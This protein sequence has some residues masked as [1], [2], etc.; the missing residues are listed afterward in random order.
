M[1]SIKEIDRIRKSKTVI[2]IH[3]EI[4]VH[5]FFSNPEI[6]YRPRFML[7]CLETVEQNLEGP[8]VSDKES[9]TTIQRNRKCRTP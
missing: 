5:A 2:F 9:N 1:P 3:G 4:S 8:N 6:E 7:H